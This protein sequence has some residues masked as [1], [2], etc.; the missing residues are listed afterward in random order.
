MSDLVSDPIWIDVEYESTKKHRLIW[1]QCYVV[2]ISVAMKG[3]FR[4]VTIGVKIYDNL[5]GVGVH[6]KENSST[7]RDK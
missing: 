3:A 6:H 4:V 2:F 1:M 7:G 5:G